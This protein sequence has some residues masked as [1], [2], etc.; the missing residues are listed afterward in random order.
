MFSIFEKFRL[1]N[2]LTKQLSNYLALLASHSCTAV[3]LLNKK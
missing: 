1:K 2:L 3:I